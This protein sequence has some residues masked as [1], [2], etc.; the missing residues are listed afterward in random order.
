[1]TTD[2]L[3]HSTSRLPLWDAN[4]RLFVQWSPAFG[5]ST[6]RI[7]ALLRFRCTSS[8][9]GC[10][11]SVC[12]HLLL[13]F[14]RL[15]SPVLMVCM[16]LQLYQREGI[17][18]RF[19]APELEF[20]H[21]TRDRRTYLLNFHRL[22]PREVDTHQETGAPAHV[23]SPLAT[24]RRMSLQLRPNFLAALRTPLCAGTDEVNTK[25]REHHRRLLGEASAFLRERLVP[26]VAAGLLTSDTRILDHSHPEAPLL[27]TTATSMSELVLFLHE[28]GVNLRHLG[29]VRSTLLRRRDI[30]PVQRARSTAFATVC[31]IEM[32]AR[33]IKQITRLR[34]RQLTLMH[35]RP[36]AGPFRRMIASVF[37]QAFGTANPEDGDAS[38]VLC[39]WNV[40]MRATLQLVGVL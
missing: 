20:Y 22:I 17:T 16:T 7:F 14:S 19:L 35:Q 9:T 15:S 6:E 25:D 13:V 21:S 11:S 1:V 38:P 12:V 28:N 36:V 3:T 40:T 8:L 29:R 18:H 4:A 23:D 32:C 33:T 5:W 24:A 37:N 31:L 34:W 26:A 10:C 2:L 30:D 27:A 39:F